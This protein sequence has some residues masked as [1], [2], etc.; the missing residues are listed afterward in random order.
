MNL[1]INFMK[2]IT[3]SLLSQDGIEID[4]EQVMT[5]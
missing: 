1:M 4:T 3:A 2:I 5:K